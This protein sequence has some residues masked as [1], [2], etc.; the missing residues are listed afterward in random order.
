MKVIKFILALGIVCLTSIS[1]AEKRVLAA[2]SDGGTFHGEKSDFRGFDRYQVQTSK[3]TIS[4]VCPKVAAPGKPWM[5]RSIFWGMQAGAVEPFTV[6]D[7]QLLEKGYHVVIAPGDVS[8]HP[9]GNANID[10]AYE[11]LTQTQGFSKKLSMASMSRETLALFSWASSN[12]EKVESIYVDNGVCNLKS[13]PGGKL[14]PGSDSKG[15]G[16]ANSWELLKKTY[17][18]T[19]DEEALAAKVS[20]I[21]LLEPLAE[22]GVPILMGCATKD[23]TVPYEE[24]GAIM[25]ERYEKL[26]GSI[27]II[28]K[29]GQDHH[30]HGLQDP[31]P[32][33]DFILRHTAGVVDTDVS[34]KAAA[35]LRNVHRIVFLGDSITQAGDYVVDFECWLLANGINV[36][37]LNLGLSSETA[38]DLTPEENQGHLQTYGFGRPFV[39]ERLSRTLEATKPDIVFACY[40]MNDGSG[41]PADETGTKRFAEAVTHLHQTATDSGVKGIVICTPP[42]HDGSQPADDNLTRYTAWLSSKRA[43]GWQVVDIHTPMRKALDEKRANDP[44]FKFASDGVHPGREGHWLMAREILTECFS[45]KLDGVASAEDLFPAHGA[46]IRKLVQKRMTLQFNARMTAIGHGRPG[47]PGGPNAQPGPSQ[48]EADAKSAEITK[49]IN[50]T[51]GKE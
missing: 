12:P 20:P 35:Q 15:S 36:E 14:V 40:G 45:A 42:I 10:A 51:L 7:V 29:E 3:G 34:A 22:A 9:K 23:A 47:V 48:A 21:D 18:F 30:P 11:T 38:T 27:Q 5:W 37:V 24:N 32:V 31:A 49:Q 44:A 6:A 16:D 39:S 19:S 26:G 50:Q 17:G 28:L 33:V 1:H 13:W 41:L 25:K 46:E 8:G 43:D 2:A 4:V